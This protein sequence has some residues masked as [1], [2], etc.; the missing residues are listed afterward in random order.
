MDALTW[1]LPIADHITGPAMRYRET[2]DEYPGNR[3]DSQAA[4]DQL[5][6]H[7]AV[8]ACAYNELYF[9]IWNQGYLMDTDGQSGPLG[10]ARVNGNVAFGTPVTDVVDP[11]RPVQVRSDML[12]NVHEAGHLFGLWHVPPCPGGEDNPYPHGDDGRVGPARGWD[13]FDR[14]FTTADDDYDIMSCYGTFD[15]KEWT[16]SDFSYQAMAMRC[17]YEYATRTCAAPGPLAPEGGVSI[18][19]IA[20]SD[21]PPWVPRRRGPAHGRVARFRRRTRVERA[22]SPP[23]RGRGGRRARHPVGGRHSRLGGHR[24]GHPGRFAPGPLTPGTARALS[25]AAGPSRGATFPLPAG[26]TPAGSHACCRFS[27]ICSRSGSGCSSRSSTV[28]CAS[29]VPCSS[30]PGASSR[31]GACTGSAPADC[32]PRR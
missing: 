11:P 2:G 7:N 14:R 10:I 21:N 32:R 13:F 25:G 3:Y 15:G 19:F 17:Q 8:H 16:V 6:E 31:A 29:R 4:L 30:I 9:G 24:R 1:Q 28:R 20:P 5:A 18:A 26:R 27:D 23:R 22:D 12:I